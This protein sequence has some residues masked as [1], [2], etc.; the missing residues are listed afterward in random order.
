MTSPRPTLPPTQ[1]S[2]PTHPT[3]TGPGRTFLRGEH[4]PELM[5]PGDPGPNGPSEPAPRP[6]TPVPPLWPAVSTAALLV[7]S[8]VAS[9]PVAFCVYLVVTR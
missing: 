5:Y 2:G 4:G 3:P 8:L 9:G 6:G 7:G 1:P